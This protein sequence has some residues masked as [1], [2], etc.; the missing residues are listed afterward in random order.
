MYSGL[1]MLETII[2]EVNFSFWDCFQEHSRYTGQHW[3]GGA[4]SGTPHEVK[5]ICTNNLWGGFSKW[6]D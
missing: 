3:K 5:R 6:K 1:K 2:N 4:I